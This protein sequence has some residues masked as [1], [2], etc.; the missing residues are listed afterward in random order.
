[1]HQ[2]TL[3]LYLV[4]CIPVIALKSDYKPPKEQKFKI[5][6]LPPEIFSPGLYSP[7]S[8]SLCSLTS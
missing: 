8:A 2:K 3:L 1:M 7:L 5:V 6:I 4:S